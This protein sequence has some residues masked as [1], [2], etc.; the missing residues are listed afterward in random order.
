MS[1]SMTFTY[2][3]DV[4]ATLNTLTN[5]MNPD[6]S[7]SLD[8]LSKENYDASLDPRTAIPNAANQSIFMNQSIVWWINNLNSG[9]IKYY[10]FSNSVNWV[11]TSSSGDVHI[12]VSVSSLCIPDV[13]QSQSIDASGNMITVFQ[14]KFNVSRLDSMMP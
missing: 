3:G 2:S 12:D 11:F 10:P 9:T 13:I 4:S 6:L 7:K 8:D 1:V 14:N 5:A